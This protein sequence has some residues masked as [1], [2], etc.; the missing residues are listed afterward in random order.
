V[1][2]GHA[3]LNCDLRKKAAGAD[4]ALIVVE[5]G[6]FGQLD[7]GFLAAE[8]LKDN[9]RCAVLVNKAREEADQGLLDLLKELKIPY[10][11]SIPF[12]RYFAHELSEGKVLAEDDKKTYR[13][14]QDVLAL[15]VATEV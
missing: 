3:R 12:N 14:M 5:A 4:L 10:V 6:V 11:G 1:L 9:T 7:I 8:M 2:D 15:L 13:L